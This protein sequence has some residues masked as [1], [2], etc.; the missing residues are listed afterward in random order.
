MHLANEIFSA[1]LQGH[2]LVGLKRRFKEFRRTPKH[3]V[4]VKPDPKMKENLRV[5]G[6]EDEVSYRRHLNVLKNESRKMKPNQGI[7]TEL[8]GLTFTQRRAEIE[9]EPHHAQE[10][11]D[12]FPALRDYNQVCYSTLSIWH[13]STKYYRYLI[14]M[15]EGG[16]TCLSIFCDSR[17]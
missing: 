8:M 9:R 7:I 17:H 4:R 6:C 1:F 11:L 10:I 14:K 3:M 12:K 5:E 15:R 2:I 16:I 13:S